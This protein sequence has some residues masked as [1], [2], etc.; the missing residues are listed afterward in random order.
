ML[1]TLC[2]VTMVKDF[3]AL[4][5]TSWKIQIQVHTSLVIIC[6]VSTSITHIQKCIIQALSKT[7]FKKIHFTQILK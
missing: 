1:D 6:L 5:L 2:L 3:N 7:Y 4:H